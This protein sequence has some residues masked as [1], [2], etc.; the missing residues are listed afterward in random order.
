MKSTKWKKTTM[1][2][3][4]FFSL[5]LIAIPMPGIT[6]QSEDDLSPPTTGFEDRDGESWTTHEE[7]LAFLEEL[8][9]RSERMTFSQVGTS[10]NGMPIHLVRVGYPEPPSDEDIANG[11][12]IMINGTPH[13]NEPAG[14]EMVLKQMR[15]LAFTDDPEKLD[16]LNESTVL[17]IPT[18]NPDGREAN[19]RT[20][21]WGI[22][23]NRGNFNLMTP[24][25]QTT[26]AMINQFQPEIVVDAHER[27]GRT[28][29]IEF[30]HS[31]NL[32]VYEPLQ[33]LNKE[34]IE[35]YLQP[36]VEEDGFTTGI[37]PTPDY[38]N[39]HERTLT[40][41]TGL[42]HG[43]GVLYE[44]LTSAEPNERVD[45]QMSATDSLLQFYIERFEDIEEAATDAPVKK[46]EDG[47][48]QEP[49][50]LAGS[51]N[52]SPPEWAVMD[53]AP[54]GYLL[55]NSQA[56]HIE[57]HIELYSLET[58]EVG[59]NKVFVT[60][61]QPMM[62]VIPLLL[63]ERARLNEVSGV[64]LYDCTAPGSEEPAQT[65]YTTNLENRVELL[66]ESD[67]FESDLEKRA[68]TTH[69]TAVGQ[70]E[71]QEQ[72]EKVVKH[73]GVFKNL[74]NYQLDHDLISEWAYNFLKDDA[75]YMIREWK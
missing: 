12:N 3:I 15:D 5:F 51:D 19:T 17:F 1:M 47:A 7:E 63:D 56:E 21:A 14:R 16:M 29:D 32:N 65:P 9:A 64:A 54:C 53:P 55:H 27:S 36:D 62:T 71:S 45:V 41:N 26:A 31:R 74:I 60:M 66:A 70:Y 44:S 10:V 20:N 57:R 2:I 18:P 67:A 72:A 34:L 28:D 50:Y 75:E 73:M 13:G 11:R 48:N 6:A 46:A 52:L 59:D 23:N 38:I 49:F 42:R 35:D 4:L 61:N 37:Y 40:N 33:E 8:A 68:V 25:N 22:D 69:L 58:E 39:G 24:E 43:M 30:M